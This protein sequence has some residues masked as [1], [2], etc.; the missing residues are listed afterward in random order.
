MSDESPSRTS[1]GS[2]A[3]CTAASASGLSDSPEPEHLYPF[4]LFSRRALAHRRLIAAMIRARPSGLRLR[5]FLPPF[6][7]AGGAAV[8]SFGFSGSGPSLPLS[9]SHAPAHSGAQDSSRHSSGRGRSGWQAAQSL[10]KVGH[11]T[12]VL[13]TLA[14]QAELFALAITG[15]LAPSSGGAGS[16]E[17]G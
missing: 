17:Q 6:A 5:F 9:G 16:P 10:A 13:P 2:R 4:A 12:R 7:G 15:A 11:A 3:C 8:S 14:M 1:A